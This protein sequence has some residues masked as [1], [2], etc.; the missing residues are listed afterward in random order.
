M[1]VTVRIVALLLIVTV[2][3]CKGKTVKMDPRLSSPIKT[4]ELWLD[5]AVKGDVAASLVCV[6]DASK[7]FVGKVKNRDVF[8]ERLT[9]SAKI[10]RDSYSIVDTKIKD[11]GAIILLKGANG[12]T[13]AVPFKKD[14]EGWKV[15]LIAMFSM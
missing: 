12:D 2:L 15:D 9:Y 10:F 14:G 3:G 6:T 13:I 5:A 4:Y 7:E 11:E 1:K 8:L